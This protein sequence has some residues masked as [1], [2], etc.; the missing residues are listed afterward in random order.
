MAVARALVRRRQSRQPQERV[1]AGVALQPMVV[2]IPV[3]GERK[4]QAQR[5]VGVVRGDQMIEGGAVVVVLA[6]AAR[7]PLLALRRR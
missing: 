2:P 1:E 6:L 5:P 7:Q 4:A 3:V